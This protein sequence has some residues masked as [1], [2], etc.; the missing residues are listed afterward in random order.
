MAVTKKQIDMTGQRFGK[1]TVIKAAGTNIHK[2]RLWEC[3][4]DCG[5]HTTVTGSDLRNGH[6][7]TCGC[8]W[9]KENAAVFHDAFVEMRTSKGETF[10][11]DIDDYNLIKGTCW[12]MNS[13]GYITGCVNGKDVLMHRILTGCNDD[14]LVDHINHNRADN[15]RRNLRIVNHSQNNMNK[16]IQKNNT[17]QHV[18]VSFNK[19]SGAWVA[20][21]AKDRKQIHL[22]SFASKQGAIEARRKA[23]A[24]LFG[25]YSY[26]ESQAIAI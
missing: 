10:L 17:S 13:H 1:L 19:K 14:A 11:V 21:I 22:G 4:C 2:K 23:E 3:V 24:E 15:R 25:E 18:G 6:T 26:T 7:K 9:H 20:F 8:A 5:K 16:A 12:W